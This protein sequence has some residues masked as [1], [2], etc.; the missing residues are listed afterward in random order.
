MHALAC[1]LL[2][3][4]KKWLDS[5][6]TL[7]NCTAFLNNWYVKS[8]FACFAIFELITHTSA[9]YCFKLHFVYYNQVHIYFSQHAVFF[10]QAIWT[11]VITFFSFDLSYLCFYSF[12]KLFTLMMTEAKIVFIFFD[13]FTQYVQHIFSNGSPLCARGNVTLADNL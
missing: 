7:K 6:C 4:T 2:N 5:P 3:D 9:I 10:L 13:L 11:S 8:Y 1:F 12:K